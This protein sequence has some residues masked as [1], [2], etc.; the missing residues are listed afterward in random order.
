MD[1]AVLALSV[2]EDFAGG[3]MLI[4]ERLES[5][6]DGTFGRPGDPAFVKNH[7]HA[8]I[9]PFQ[10]NAPRPPTVAHEVVGGRP[11]DA[12]AGRGPGRMTLGEFPAVPIGDPF[13]AGPGGT[14]GMSQVGFEPAFLAG[15]N[16]S[17]PGGVDDP[18]GGELKR[19]TVFSNGDVLGASGMELDRGDRG[20]PPTHG[21]GVGG[22][23]QDFF[24]ENGAVHLIGRQADEVAAADF[25][26]VGEIRCAGVL[27][28]E[29]HALLDEVALVE[30]A[31]QAK[32]AA[33]E[34]P[35]DLDGGLTDP[36]TEGGRAFQDENAKGGLFA[37]Q[38][39]GG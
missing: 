8:D 9:A 5:G 26:T 18:S 35:A 21:A 38:K 31:G 27:E 37:E 39:D 1:V 19:G 11:A 15:E 14:G 32:D 24:V 20:G 4:Q 25:G 3:G 17:D 13:P 36:P 33:Q 7:P 2:G 10:R 28:P 30:V 34:K 23:L 12:R 22:Q 6:T 29:P 16:G